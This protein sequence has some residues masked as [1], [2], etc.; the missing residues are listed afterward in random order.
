MYIGDY[1]KLQEGRPPIPPTDLQGITVRVIGEEGGFFT[2]RPWKGSGDL[3]FK[4]LGFYWVIVA[5]AFKYAS[6]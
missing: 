6:Y 3:W 2:V 4:G 1:T 5:D